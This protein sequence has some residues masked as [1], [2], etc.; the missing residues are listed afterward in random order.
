MPL[1]LHSAGGNRRELADI[2]A[3]R[4]HV[5]LAADQHDADVRIGLG[6]DDGVGQCAIHRIGQRVLLV[7]AR[8]RKAK[9]AV[10]VFDLDVLC[11]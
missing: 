3:G 10:A 9:D 11:H 6:G 4:K 8:Y 5:A 1:A 7:W 2:I